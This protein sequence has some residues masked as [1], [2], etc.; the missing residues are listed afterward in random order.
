[1]DT[2]RSEGRRRRIEASLEWLARYDA[3]VD[4][5][6]AF[7][8]ALEPPAPVDLLVH[9]GRTT[10]AALG[11][12]LAARGLAVETFAW[13]P[14]HLRVAAGAAPLPGAGTL[15]EVVFGYALPQGASSATAARALAPR[16]GELVA[17]L[18]AAPGGKTAL[19]SF[20]AGD[21]ARIVAGDPSA[22]RC[23]LLVTN[24]ARMALTGPL[25]VQQD[26]AALPPV[27][28]FDAILLDA[29]CTGEGTFR[30]ASP[31][32]EP[33]GEAG[34]GP[35]RALQ[36]RLLARALDRL[37][38]GGRLV[39]ATCS[40]APEENE[41]VLADALAARDDVTLVPLPDGMP[42]QPGLTAWNGLR[43]PSRMT[44]AR[45][46]FPHHTGSWGFFLAK[47][48]K[49]A[50][51]ASA[52]GATPVQPPA[53]DPEARAEL[54]AVLADRFG[55]DADAALADQV[56]TARGRDLWL[57]ARSA[58]PGDRDVDLSALK[59][60]APGMR[61]L[62]RT[63]TGP[64][65]TNS[66]LRWLGPRITQRV[67]EL[68]A[69]TARRLL[70]DGPLP[71]PDPALRGGVAVRVDGVVVGAGHIREGVLQFEIPAAWR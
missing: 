39:Y 9:P 58:A 20:L 36:R 62:H 25:V 51:D 67:V 32:Y 21:R 44:L 66:L 56:V 38:P 23:G 45:R 3:I 19:L 6:A 65:V 31:R 69:E 55:V 29:P 12:A 64:R 68:D 13:A 53:D 57:L 8:A 35:A 26:A 71:C 40:Y 2:P 50:G 59:V 37:A 46:L 70:T 63:N 5:P 16:A 17:D 60:V 28:L 10:P 47:L 41:E 61:A 33:R 22:D 48:E 4:D 54:A 24:L 42:G 15:P 49:R 34:L 11:A 43:F 18:C 1:M 14:H 7:R 30:L 52:D 27:A